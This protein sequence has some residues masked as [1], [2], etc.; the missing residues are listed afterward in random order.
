MDNSK[1]IYADTDAIWCKGWTF[2]KVYATLTPDQYHE[3]TEVKQIEQKEN[4]LC[5]QSLQP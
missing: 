5:N 4:K 3:V 2:D 1:F